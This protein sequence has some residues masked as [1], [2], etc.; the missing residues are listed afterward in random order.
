VNDIVE[1]LLRRSPYALAWTKRAINR[2]IVDAL[3]M[4]LD[5]GAAYE[6]VNFLHLE[7]LGGQEPTALD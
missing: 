3:N 6:M 7:R 5:T 2:R 4:S 1:R